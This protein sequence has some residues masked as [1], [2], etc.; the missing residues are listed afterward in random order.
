VLVDTGPLVAALS[1]RDLHHEQCLA[2]FTAVAVGLWTCWP[3]VTEAA[4]LLRKSPDAVRALLRQIHKDN[5]R[6]L[7]LD[8][9]DSPPILVILARDADSKLDFADACLMHLA[10]RE[11]IDFVF[12]LDRRHFSLFR[13]S[14]GSALQ[15]IPDR[16][17]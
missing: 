6:I 7:P 3:V 17:A 10:E 5:L 8:E 12:T 4:Y 2:E 1:R 15:L 11:A 9:T 13:K 14:D 16:S